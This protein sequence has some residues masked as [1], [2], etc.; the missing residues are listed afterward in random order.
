MEIV[1]KR[2]GKSYVPLSDLSSI[3]AGDYYRIST[4]AFMGPWR[5]AAQ[6]AQLSKG[7]WIVRPTTSKLASNNGYEIKHVPLR[8][9]G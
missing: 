2:A 6:D 9:M 3:K 7:R 5:R 1:H 8:R 4:C